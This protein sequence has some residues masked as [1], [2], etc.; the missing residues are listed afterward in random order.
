MT[1]RFLFGFD[2]E[3]LTALVHGARS[4]LGATLVLAHGASAGQK[5]PF[6]VD[7]A[8]ALAERGLLV[9]TFDF[10]YAEHG[11][12]TPDKN[13]VLKAAY[14]AAA[15]AARRCRTKNRL[16]LGG[17]SLGGRIATQIVVDGGDE[18]DDVA[19]I[20]VL[21]Y[22][23]H[24]IGEPG[25]THERHL[26]SLPTPALFVQGE[27]DVFGTPAELRRALGGLPDAT[28]HVVTGG[29]HSLVPPKAGRIPEAE[30]RAEVADEVARW[31]SEH[32]S[33]HPARRGGAVRRLRSQ[34]REL[35]S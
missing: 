4:P 20:V 11:R 23:L 12:R 32:L 7:Y 2:G 27:R 3:R 29:D 17:K 21:G 33:S 22:P 25:G 8:T 14:R 16:F 34:L 10:P 18:V 30:A 35:R 31:I 9:V 24:P 15:V 6:V 13:D 28:I 1:E 5:N 26:R 19:G